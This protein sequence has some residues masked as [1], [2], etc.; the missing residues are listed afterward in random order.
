[1]LA[2]SAYYFTT[3]VSNGARSLLEARF[4]EIGVLLEALGL[5]LCAELVFKARLRG[6]RIALENSKPFLNTK[7]NKSNDSLII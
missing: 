4:L 2:A 3:T 1:M 7:S 5:V 6:C